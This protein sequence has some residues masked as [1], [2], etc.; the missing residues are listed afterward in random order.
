MN[1]VDIDIGP[2]TADAEFDLPAP[3]KLSRQLTALADLSSQKGVVSTEPINV[4]MIGS[5]IFYKLILL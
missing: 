5:G 4:L 2:P 1:F 3:P